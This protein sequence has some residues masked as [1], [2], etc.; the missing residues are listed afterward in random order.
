MT[1]QYEPIIIADTDD[2]ARVKIE[3]DGRAEE[4]AYFLNPG[5]LLAAPF[6][7]S[8]PVNRRRDCLLGE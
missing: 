8:T 7:N 1:E 3:E 2:L 6:A 4:M 5:P